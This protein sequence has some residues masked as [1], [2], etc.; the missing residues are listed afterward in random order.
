MGKG[1]GSKKK[2]LE[3]TGKTIFSTSILVDVVETIGDTTA[4]I[5]YV[6]QKSLMTLT[7]VTSHILNQN[8]V[9]EDHQT[10]IQSG[11]KVSGEKFITGQLE[12]D[13]AVTTQYYKHY[14]KLT[15]LG[16]SLKTSTKFYSHNL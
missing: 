12:Q 6:K 4:P 1:I 15:M 3:W 8:Q 9:I 2:H 13:K 16:S 10:T 7:T 11:T 5:S 14:K